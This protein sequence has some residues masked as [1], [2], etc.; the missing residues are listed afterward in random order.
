[1]TLRG[2]L[3]GYRRRAEPAIDIGLQAERT[4]MAWQRTAL[5]VAGVSGLLLH[6]ADRSLVAS[7]PG[8]VGLVAAVV[9]LGAGDRR[10]TR[11]V[12]RVEDG[13]SPLGLVS[14]RLVTVGVVTLSV[15][16]VA[17]LAVKT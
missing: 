11:T 3:F 16:A 4:A 12:R 7:A 1:M 13:E 14:V 9:L 6:V 10:Y 17:L 2:R 5:G 8:V 15:S